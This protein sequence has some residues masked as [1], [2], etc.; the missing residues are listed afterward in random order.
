MRF[1]IDITKT[2]C[3]GGGE[4]VLQSRFTISERALVLFGPSGSGKTLTLKAIAGLL[5]PDQ[6]LIRL[7]G[8][9]VESFAEAVVV[10]RNG[11]V[12][13]VHSARQLAEAGKSLGETI[14]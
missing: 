1:S 3:G 12:D 8:D 9:E 10:Y 14:R 5:R 7:N 4:F 13:G 2:M 11:Q 6:G